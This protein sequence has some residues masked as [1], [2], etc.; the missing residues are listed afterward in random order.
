MVC[1]V[2]TN[3]RTHISFYILFSYT[4]YIVCI[5]IVKCSSWSIYDNLRS[6]V[7]FLTINF[8]SKWYNQYHLAYT[9]LLCNLR[10]ITIGHLYFKHA[11]G[12]VLEVVS[13]SKD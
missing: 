5:S 10:Y 8:N 2:T 7:C 6:T 11:Y 3:D 12:R 4:S 1:S 13:R 9:M